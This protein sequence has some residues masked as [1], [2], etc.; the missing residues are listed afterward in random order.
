METLLETCAYLIRCQGVYKNCRIHFAQNFSKK[1]ILS[2][3]NSFIFFLE[4][5]EDDVKV[6]Q[7]LEEDQEVF[8][9][10][11]VIRGNKRR[12]TIESCSL[13]FTEVFW[14]LYHF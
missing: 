2:V 7:V 10:K 1:K 5:D 12:K 9:E 4:K 6:N 3:H 14:F 13:V 8:R 11:K